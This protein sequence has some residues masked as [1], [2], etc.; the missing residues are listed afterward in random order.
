MAGGADETLRAG[1]EHVYE[2]DRT[3]SALPDLSQAGAFRQAAERTATAVCHVCA[4]AQTCR[5]DSPIVQLDAV[6]LRLRPGSRLA[7]SAPRAAPASTEIVVNASLMP[8][9]HQA[10]ELRFTDLHNCGHGCAFPC[11]ADGRV[12]LLDLSVR[13]LAKY[14]LAQADVGSK[15]SCPFVMR[16]A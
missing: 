6:P 3:P 5:R 11:D 8:S 2:V 13:G 12:S 15:L 4:S 1:P 10:Y 9:T 16:T 7:R 14:L